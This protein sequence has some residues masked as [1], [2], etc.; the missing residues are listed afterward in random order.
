MGALIGETGVFISGWEDTEAAALSPSLCVVF[1][2]E[3]FI[4]PLLG[5]SLPERN[6]QLVPSVFPTSEHRPLHLPASGRGRAGTAERQGVQSCCVTHSL[7]TRSPA[8]ASRA[9]WRWPWLPWAPGRELRARQVAA[10][11]GGGSAGPAELLT[12]RPSAFQLPFS[13][14]CWVCALL[15]CCSFVRGVLWVYVFQKKTPLLILGGFGML[16]A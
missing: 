13:C 9:A 4:S 15:F 8:P 10:G 12:T 5:R 16:T 7:S 2:K 11:V 3:L 14:C 1:S 6:R